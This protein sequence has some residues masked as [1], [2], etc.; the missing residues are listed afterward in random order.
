MLNYGYS[1]QTELSRYS[2]PPLS[3]QLRIHIMVHPFLRLEDISLSFG[4]YDTLTDSPW[5]LGD[6]GS[7]L[8]RIR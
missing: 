1:E 8:L 4:I 6:R 3:K 5:I 2:F 7:R